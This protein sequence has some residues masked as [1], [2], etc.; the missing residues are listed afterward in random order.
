MKTCVSFFLICSSVLYSACNQ[1]DSVQ[2]SESNRADSLQSIPVQGKK[3][4]IILPGLDHGMEQSPINISSSTNEKG[5]HKISLFFKDSINKIEN[6]GHTVQLDFNEGSSIT[7]DD[8]SFIF[9]QCHFHTPSEHHIDGIMYPMEMHI[10]SLMPDT[11]KKATPQYLV[12]SALFKEGK[13]SKFIADFLSS[14]PKNENEKAAV[15]GGQVKLSDLFGSVSKEV[16]GQYY[17]YRGSLT[18]PP[19]TESVRWH[20]TKHIFEASPEQIEALHTI[21]GNNARQVQATFGR[22]VAND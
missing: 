2:S 20:V 14:I 13:E 5:H 3:D 16:M 15:R 1:T 10:V 7:Q 4:G 21:E 22:V 9:K 17:Y 18:T 6:L 19:Y 8:T 11:N 12:I